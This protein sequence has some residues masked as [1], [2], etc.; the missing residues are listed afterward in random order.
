MRNDSGQDNTSASHDIGYDVDEPLE[1]S[2]VASKDPINGTL[3]GLATAAA[4]V[5]RAQA[6]GSLD[7]LVIKVLTLR[8]AK[9]G[10]R[11]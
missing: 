6:R 1:D 2:N 5:G 3:D 7:H 4:K 11:V 9:V 8:V 10:I